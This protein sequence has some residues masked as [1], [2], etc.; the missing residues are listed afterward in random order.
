MPETFKIRG[1]CIFDEEHRRLRP[2]EEGKTVISV[3]GFDNVEMEMIEI[4]CACPAYALVAFDD[5]DRGMT[6]GHVG[7]ATAAS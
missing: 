2:I 3:C 1:R 7:C 4:A 6:A 5:G